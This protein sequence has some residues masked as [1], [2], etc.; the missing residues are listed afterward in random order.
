VQR[1]VAE[2]YMS[3]KVRGV[4]QGCKGGDDGARAE[5]QGA[6]AVAG[7]VEAMGGTAGEQFELEE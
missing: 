1:V 7:V 3:L 2:V 6:L 5:V 4:K